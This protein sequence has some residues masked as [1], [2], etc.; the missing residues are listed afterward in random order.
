MTA[1]DLG[2]VFVLGLL[3]STHCV[4]MCGAFVACVSGGKG[5]YQFG[6]LATYVILGMLLG[7]AGMGVREAWESGGGRA[8]LVLCGILMVGMGLRLAGA[9]LPALGARWSVGP[10]R[11]VGATMRGF[12]ASRSRF[13]PLGLGLLSGLLPCGLLYVALL[14]AA[15]TASALEGGA[16]MAA[17]W[18]G[19]TPA[20]LGVGIL[21]PWM[22]ERAPRAW[23]LLAGL[24]VIAVGVITA[25]HGLAAPHA[26]CQ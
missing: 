22:R 1:A 21:G 15:A 8:V 9:P 20:L 17:F 14:R 12:L 16:V 13:A 18:A 3:G 5:G 19:T 6:R 25:S 2:T 26:C 24:A 23:P 4:G 10:L 11:M 7:A